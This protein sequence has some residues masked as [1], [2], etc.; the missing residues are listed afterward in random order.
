MKQ[1]QNQL[2]TD[3]RNIRKS[4]C[5]NR[6]NGEIVNPV[7]SVIYIFNKKLNRFLSVKYAYIH[8]DKQ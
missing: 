5:K 6:V 2:F 8:C 4:L 3:H 7:Y 1:Q